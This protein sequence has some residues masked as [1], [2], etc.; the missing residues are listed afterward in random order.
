MHSL[1]VVDYNFDA[2]EF[3]MTAA[4]DNNNSDE[5]EYGQRRCVHQHLHLCM[6][7]MMW[8]IVVQ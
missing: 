6:L 1:D 7:I 2:F 5:T 3:D 4:I 8:N